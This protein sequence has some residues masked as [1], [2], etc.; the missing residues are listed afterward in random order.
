MHCSRSWSVQDEV[1]QT[2]YHGEMRVSLVLVV[3]LVAACLSVRSSPA[4]RVERQ[5]PSKSGV[6]WRARHEG[7]EFAGAPRR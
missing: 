6:E 5:A 4:T 1:L 2:C 7:E 3:V